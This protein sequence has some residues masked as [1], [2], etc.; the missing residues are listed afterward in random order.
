MPSTAG[1]ITRLAS[2][3]YT[4]RMPGR[5][6]PERATFVGSAAATWVFAALYFCCYAPYSALAKAL[7][8]GAK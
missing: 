8:S 6:R 5:S 7:S 2:R 1:R 4:L 3:P